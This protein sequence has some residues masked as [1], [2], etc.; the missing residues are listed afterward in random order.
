MKQDK[1]AGRQYEQ[2]RSTKGW[3][4]GKKITDI[5]E[6]IVG[7]IVIKVSHQFKSENLVIITPVENFPNR[8]IRYCQYVKPD[9][10][11]T[12]DSKVHEAAIWDFE[13]NNPSWQEY[14]LAVKRKPR[15]RAVN[16]AV[17]AEILGKV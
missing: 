14:F 17:P 12:W 3:H 6:L 11:P 9:G 4:R 5:S 7:M 13:L 15:R 2:G 16:E 1:G 8:P 10:T